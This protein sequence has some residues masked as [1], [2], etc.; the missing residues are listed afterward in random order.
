LAYVFIACVKII[1]RATEDETPLTGE[2]EVDEIYF[3]GFRKCKRGL[4]A[5]SKVPVFGLLNG[6]SGVCA[7]VIPNTKSKTLMGII[8][9]RIVPGSMVYSDGYQSYNVLDVSEF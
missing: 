1:I 3:G 9:D 5:A 7:K 8:Q 6:S 4:G 2:I